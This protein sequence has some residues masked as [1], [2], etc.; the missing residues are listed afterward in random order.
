MAAEFDIFGGFVDPKALDAFKQL[1]AQAERTAKS[2]KEIATQ[3][4]AI[5][6][7]VNAQQTKGGGSVGNTK[8]FD[9]LVEA[10]KRLTR[11]MQ[12]L[13]IQQ[14]KVTAEMQKNVV[15][16]QN[17]N[18]TLKLQAT[19]VSENSTALQK[20]YATMKLLEVE[21]QSKFNPALAEQSQE[22]RNLNAQHSKL[23]Q[24]YQRT[25][26]ATGVMGRSMNSTYGS[27]FQMTQVMRELPNFAIDAR[28]GFMALSNNLPMLADSFQLLKQ[29]I[30]D[31]E[32]AA[33]ATGKTWA[34]F[35]RSLLSLNTIMI[36]A[37]TLLVLFGDN[38]IEVFTG[39]VPLA[40]KAN[41]ELVKS[42]RAGNSEFNT[43]VETYFRLTAIMDSA[44]KGFISQKDAVDEYNKAF[45]K[46]NGYVSTFEEAQLRLQQQ[47]PAYVEAMIMMAYANKFLEQA[48]KDYSEAEALRRDKDVSFFR[49]VGQFL[50]PTV[51]GKGDGKSLE[52]QVLFMRQEE[53]ANKTKDFK[54]NMKMFIDEY[55]KAAKFLQANKIDIWGDDKKPKNQKSPKD[56]K[57]M[58]E[59]QGFSIDEKT[60]SEERLRLIEVVAKAEEGMLKETESG[61]LNSYAKRIRM[62]ESF[63]NAKESLFELEYKDAEANLIKKN[64]LDGDEIAKK[65][66]SNDKLFEEGKM[67][68]ERH[69]ELQNEFNIATKTLE[70]N[71]QVDM[72]E[73]KYKYNKDNEQ[74]KLQFTKNEIRIVKDAVNEI[75]RIQKEQLDR[76][77]ES[78]QMGYSL[79]KELMNS[80]Y[81]IMTKNLEE[82]IGRQNKIED[83]KYK[84][85]EDRE[86][87][88]IITKQQAEE[89][90][91]NTQAYYDSINEEAERKKAQ[92]ERDAF[93]L[94]QAIA[95]ADI[96][97]KF[98][99]ASASYQAAIAE[100]SALTA[101]VGTAPAIVLY[102]SLTAKALK[103]AIFG[104]ALVAAQTI[105]AFEKGGDVTE[106]GLSLV[107]EKRHELVYD[108]K[109]G[110]AF[111]T[112][113]KP[114]LMNLEKGMHVYPNIDK[115]DLDSF[116]LSQRMLPMVTQD[117]RLLDEIKQLN[118]TMSRQK[119]P[120][121]NGMRLMQQMQYAERNLSNRKGLLN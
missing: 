109:T 29:E 63:R 6:G 118:R 82:W 30:I 32:G 121:I 108:P 110:R 120:Q 49:K 25:A 91:A 43:A 54:Q 34:A 114:T 19:L 45:G 11:S 80:F 60:F 4:D 15:T 117:D 20:M 22:F 78:Q 101:G 14:Q 97:L 68:E 41:D 83:E 89:E 106:S 94:S 16:R 12:E 33:G 5:F 37:S 99:Q 111:I 88:G 51:L 42:I 28:V 96:W 23:Q 57:Q 98:A 64:A 39:K 77:L 26:R 90:K 35:G 17:S 50:N 24:E 31:T 103:Q 8:E 95:V 93:L 18:A 92:Q 53:A 58:Q 36:V 116:N 74:N 104:T 107:G 67:T 52:E 44:S 48:V 86:N 10:N 27:T 76:N 115:M 7:K 55:G 100:I 47:A 2:M 1:E 87:A 113:D 72:K 38:I 61:E 85:I 84:D 102:G 21:M 46:T 73:L 40:T 70:N 79:L 65:M 71:F 3:K 13:Q 9:A 112:P 75:E 56:A 69:L 62:A 66:E 105:P 59:G 81:E 119:S